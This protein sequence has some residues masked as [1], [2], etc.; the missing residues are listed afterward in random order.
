VYPHCSFFTP[1]QGDFMKNSVF[2]TFASVCGFGFIA[3]A[4]V[5]VSGKFEEFNTAITVMTAF[6][7][8]GVMALFFAINSLHGQIAQ[9]QD[10][11][12]DVNRRIHDEMR[13][14]YQYLEES[15]RDLNDT[16]DVEIR[17]V[18]SQISSAFDQINEMRD[19]CTTESCKA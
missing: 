3:L 15:K 4:F 16:V 19:N 9:Q 17:D 6:F 10:A 18:Q 7:V 2:S 11:M 5:G 14:V 8:F 12:D 1:N 13:D